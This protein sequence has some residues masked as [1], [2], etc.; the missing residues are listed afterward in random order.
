MPVQ[1]VNE[2]LIRLEHHS[3]VSLNGRARRGDDRSTSFGGGI[4]IVLCRVGEMEIDSRHN[5]YAHT[6][7]EGSEIKE[8]DPGSS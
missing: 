3:S 8:E 5:P 1:P 4:N 2:P 7:W 6:A